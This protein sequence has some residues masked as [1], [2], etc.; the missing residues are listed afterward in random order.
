MII[1]VSACL[2][3]QN[4]KYSGGNNEN[5]AVLSLEKEHTLIP[6]CPEVMGGL[7]IPRSPSEVQGARVVQKNGNDV[8]AEY[9]KGAELSL[10]LAER[11]HPDLI[12]LQPRSPSCG[13]HTRYDGTFSG[14]LIPGMG[15]AAALLT[16]HGY[17]VIDAE[18]LLSDPDILH[19]A[20]GKN[21]E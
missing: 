8:T 10:K 16:D 4:V 17:R 20:E 5:A 13:V 12:I 18:D 21:N 14:K 19:Q 1:M 11:I 6:F 9:E 7:P 15:K 3:G 2:M